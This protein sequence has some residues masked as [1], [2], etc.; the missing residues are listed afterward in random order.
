[1]YQSNIYLIKAFTWDL[2]YLVIS[3]SWIA[4]GIDST[5]HESIR[6]ERV[7]GGSAGEIFGFHF[8]I[9]RITCFTAAW[10][11]CPMLVSYL[12]EIEA[13]DIFETRRYLRLEDILKRI[14]SDHWHHKSVREILPPSNLVNSQSRKIILCFDL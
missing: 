11:V 6:R 13:K 8:D 10:S 5:S 3:L 9:T 2:Q 1:M 4:D 12:P 7:I 14:S